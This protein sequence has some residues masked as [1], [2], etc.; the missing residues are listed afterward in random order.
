M[1]WESEPRGKCFHSFTSFPILHK[2]V[3]LKYPGP[4]GF[5]LF[6]FG[7]FCDVN[8]LRS[9]RYCKCNRNNVLAVNH[10]SAISF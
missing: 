4:R 10:F 7:K 6:F 9:W 5:L 3:F 1:Q 8:S 2:F